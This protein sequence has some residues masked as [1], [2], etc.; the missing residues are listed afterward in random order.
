MRMHGKMMEFDKKK[1]ARAL[2]WGVMLLFWGALVLACLVNR[3]KITVEAIVSYTPEEP[4]LAALVML[5]LYAVKS[6][7][8]VIYGG[9]LNMASGVMFSLP[10]A[11]VVNALGTAIIA[12]IPF[13]MGRRIGTGALDKLTQQHPKLHLLQD[14]P[15]NNSFFMSF[16]IR[17][18]GIIPGD[19]VG[20]YL[21][22][23][24]TDFKGYFLGTML[25]LL[26]P[27][28]AFTV[29]GSSVYDP[30]SPRFIIASICEVGVSIV[31][32][33]AYLIWKH[34]KGKSHI[35]EAAV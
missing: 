7:S 35:E 34:A 17:I 4:I 19:L 11:L 23:A 24:G 27:V 14:V 33:A 15:R 12:V 32:L 13:V 25:G 26:P 6:I 22:A 28:C 21:G 16:L 5:V 29:M 2:Q 20:L 3:D 8:F 18:V 30:T 31:S 10:M 9:L 1:V